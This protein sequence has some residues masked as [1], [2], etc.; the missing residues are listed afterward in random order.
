MILLFENVFR[1]NEACFGH[2]AVSYICFHLFSFF[3]FQSL[4]LVEMDLAWQCFSINLVFYFFTDC[5]GQFSIFFAVTYVF[6]IYTRLSSIFF[7]NG[8]YYS[9]PLPLYLFLLSLNFSWL[10]QLCIALET[11]NNLVQSTDTN[12]RLLSEKFG[13]IEKIIKRGDSAIAAAKAMQFSLNQ[14]EG[15]SVGKSMKQSRSHQEQGFYSLYRIFPF[16]NCLHKDQEEENRDT[17]IKYVT[18]FWL[19]DSCLGKFSVLWLVRLFFSD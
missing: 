9:D 11:A 10:C 17:Y 2:L 12:V 8:F 16:K 14:K 5:C 1:I 3:L 13:E 18:L 7:Q 15:L 19:L 4:R 6:H